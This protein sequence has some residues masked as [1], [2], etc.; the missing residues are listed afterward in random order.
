MGTRPAEVWGWE[1]YPFSSRSLMVLRIVA[2]DT[3][4]PLTPSHRAA[5]RRLRRFHIGLDH[6]LQNADF[7]FREVLSNGSE[8]S[9]HVH[10]VLERSRTP[11]G[12]VNPCPRERGGRPS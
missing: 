6:G 11:G 7:P 4:K 12:S 5:S 1:R 8:T 2:G 10:H 9:G 3:P